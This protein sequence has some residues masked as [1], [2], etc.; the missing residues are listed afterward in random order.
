MA[1][2]RPGTAILLAGA[3][4]WLGLDLLLRVWLVVTPTGAAGL[5]PAL[6][7]VAVLGGVYGALLARAEPDARRALGLVALAPAGLLVL[8]LVGQHHEGVLGALGL[9]LA[10]CLGGAGGL[11]AL[12]GPAGL[13]RVGQL[14]LVPAPGLVGLVGAALVLIGTARFAGLTLAGQALAVALVGLLA[15]LLAIRGLAEGTGRGGQVEVA[16][17]TGLEGQVVRDRSSVGAWLRAGALLLPLVALG[18]WPGPGLRRVQSEPRP[19]HTSPPCPTVHRPPLPSASDLLKTCVRMACI[20][21]KA[22][23][24]DTPPIDPTM[25]ISFSGCG[26]APLAHPDRHAVRHAR[27]ACR[28]KRRA[29]P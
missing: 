4:R 12:D 17:G 7:W 22:D 25:A 3:V 6:A 20:C 19:S 9:G 11:A 1:A 18:V 26:H 28:D 29:S 8:G 5:A 13:R 16:E 24:P 14:G 27:G 15:A 23:V 21:W 2:A 10:L